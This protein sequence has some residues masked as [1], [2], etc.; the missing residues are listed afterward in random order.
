VDTQHLASAIAS[1]AACPNVCKTLTTL[2]SPAGS[3]QLFSS[4]S[5]EQN[6]SPAN[7]ELRSSEQGADLQRLP[8]TSQPM[9]VAA[10]ESQASR[11]QSSA[12]SMDPHAIA[13]RPMGCV[14]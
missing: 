13:V 9:S 3:Q 4:M 6:Q 8:S 2:P 5:F 14:P 10:L 11:A 7:Q 1:N 12:Q